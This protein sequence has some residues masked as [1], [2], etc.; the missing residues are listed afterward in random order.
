MN[1]VALIGVV[2]SIEKNEQTT[3]VNLECDAFQDNPKENYSSIVPVVVNNKVFQ[4][5]LSQLKV[6]Q[7][8]G[9]KGACNFFQNQVQ[10]K[11]P[12]IQ[13]LNESVKKQKELGILCERLQ[14]FN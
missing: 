10:V 8:I 3:A 14:I 2:K 11:N 9:V 13:D 7:I 6:G 5:E 4:D 12:K 1:F